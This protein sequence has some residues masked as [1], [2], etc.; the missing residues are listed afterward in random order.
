M[1]KGPSIL[2]SLFNIK[3]SGLSNDRSHDLSLIDRLKFETHHS[4]LRN[5]EMA[6]R[7]FSRDQNPSNRHIDAILMDQKPKENGVTVAC[8]LAWYLVVKAKAFKITRLESHS[9]EILWQRFSLSKKRAKVT[10]LIVLITELMF[11]EGR[12]EWQDMNFAK[13][14]V[15]GVVECET[16]P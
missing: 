7:S 13:G 15:T 12:I 3:A 9:A 14:C 11:D 1:S 10:S 5:L 6:Y 2:W 4:S 16:Q 8:S